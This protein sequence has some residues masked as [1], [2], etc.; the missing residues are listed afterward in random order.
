MKHKLALL[1]VG[2]FLGMGISK[3]I[4]FNVISIAHKLFDIQIHLPRALKREPISQI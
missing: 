2:L 1:L 3:C 4:P